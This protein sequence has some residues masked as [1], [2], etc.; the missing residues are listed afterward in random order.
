MESGVHFLVYEVN[1]LVAVL[2]KEFSAPFHHCHSLDNSL[3][4]S[5]VGVNKTK[6]GQRSNEYIAIYL[7]KIEIDFNKK[8]AVQNFALWSNNYSITANSMGWFCHVEDIKFEYIM[9]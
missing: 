2:I 8:K 9:I 7:Y 5:M 6:T 4:Q 1:Y 3:N